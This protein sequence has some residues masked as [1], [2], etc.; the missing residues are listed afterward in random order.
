MT[1][2][3]KN[4]SSRLSR[5]IFLY[6]LGVTFLS[7][8]TLG[9]FWIESKLSSYQ[10]DV[11]SFKQ[12]YS[13]TKRLEL[14]NKILELKDYIGWIQNFPAEPVC[15]TLETRLSRL[16]LPGKNKILQEWDTEESMPSAIKDSLSKSDVPVFLLNN[17]GRII[18]SVNPF[19]ETGV[20][21]INAD[22]SILLNRLISNNSKNETSELIFR[23]SGNS[24]STLYAAGY[25]NSKILAGYKLVS[26]VSGASIADILKLHVL[27]SISRLR[28]AENEYVFVNSLAGKALSTNG[29]YNKPPIDILTSGNSAWITIFRVEQSS[30][31]H[32]DGVFHTYSWP[33]LSDPGNSVKT[34][35]FSYL[36]EWKWIIGTGYYEDEVNS[37]IELKRQELLAELRIGIWRTS[38]YLFISIL[39]SYLLVRYFSKSLK[40]NINVFNHFFEKA[41]TEHLPIDPSKV[42]Y[43]EFEQMAKAA[44]VMVEERK[45]TEK[46]LFDSQKLLQDITDNSTPLIYALN[47]KGEFL[48]INRSLE[49]VLGISRELLIGKTRESVIPA[50]IAAA[51]RAND[52]KVM[53]TRQPV[54]VEEVNFEAGLERTYL[55]VKFPLVDYN[56]NLTGIA[57]ISTDITERKKAD[58]VTKRNE[59]LLKL[60]VEYSPAAIAMFDTDM[61][62]LIASRRY[63]ADYGL[64]DINL[65][66]RSHYE[67]FPEITE[68]WK[69]IHKSCLAGETARANEDSFPRASGKLDWVRWEIR[70]W[71]ENPEKIGGLLLFSEVITETVISKEELR[72]S[73]AYNRM[74]FEQSPIGLAVTSMDGKMIDVNP[75]F[76][77]IIGRSVEA[78]LRLTYWDLTPEKYAEQEQMQL[79]SLKKS[80]FYGPYEKEYIHKDG[81]LVQ[82]RLKG[83]LIERYGE[84]YIWS[85][86][87][88]I[89]VSKRTEEEIKKLNEGLELRVIQRTAELESFSYSISHDLRAPLRAIHGFSEILA[90]K[91]LSSLNDEG[92]KYVE[93]I[94]NS[95][96]RMQNLIN[97]LL[98]YSRLG[99]MAITLH[100]VS[101]SK[102]IDVVLTD[103]KS[104]ITEIGGKFSVAD[105]LPQISGD[106]TLLRQIFTNLIDN[107]IKYRKTDIPLRIILSSEPVPEGLVVKVTDNGIGIP[108]EYWE[109]IF[110]VFQRLHTEVKYPGTGIGLAT[111]RKAADMLGAKVWVVSEVAKGSTFFIQ[112]KR[113][114]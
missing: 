6:L 102:I 57:G 17:N 54:V 86:V 23:K 109:K 36:P 7:V 97:D 51:H 43:R 88:D 85:S 108:E 16:T 81:H 21:T 96:V 100:P 101:L 4:G 84:K 11:A 78:A 2:T 33:K 39:L 18:F 59:H 94:V 48:M 1:K 105:E 34:S 28:F 32:S 20:K 47:L 87:E 104:Q 106:E 38:L 10:R 69:K 41:A 53:D 19:S 107:A 99:S 113:E 64:G 82:V 70:P 91:H 110:N 83:L 13:E 12:N 62:Y 37:A 75:A 63:L 80:G 92:K 111:V 95:S 71:Y 24:D 73:E 79:D 14:K 77:K 49:T 68:R 40:I 72:E 76:A 90:E 15:Q 30:S 27:D 98:N 45:V 67:V 103:L 25:C 55:T 52:L 61:K 60:F 35:Y 8:A 112:F 74:L 44:N 29:V 58:E 50:E 56:G 5:T 89:S 42:S 26:M 9:S 65:V 3:E 93:Y 22:E 66:G 114:G 31:L 46:K